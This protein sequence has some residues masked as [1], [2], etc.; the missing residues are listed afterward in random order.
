MDRRAHWEHVYHT[1][2]PDSVSWFQAEARLSRA[3]IA[4]LA[5]PRDAHIID[6]GGGASVLVDELLALGYRNLSVLDVS[7]AALGHVRRRLGG[8]ASGVTWIEGDALTTTLPAGHYDVW[9]DRAV[10]HFL[11]SPEDRARYVEQVRHAVRPGGI[12]L[13]A[14]F[15]EDGPTRCSGLEVARY[16]PEALHGEFG[17]DFELIERERELHAT[18]T[19]A[20]QAF[21]YCAC[22]F[23]PAGG[24][25]GQG[26]TA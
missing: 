9:H 3:L 14:T 2:A 7:A 19:G 10:F 25:R 17:A 8:A 24:A 18:P 12:V 26:A 22:R 5:P 16:S 15:A 6:V 20:Q 21:T 23:R 13:V 4:R 11:T 1:K